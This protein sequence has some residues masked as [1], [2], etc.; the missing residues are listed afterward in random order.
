MLRC[1]CQ[2]N[3]RAAVSFGLYAPLLFPTSSVLFG[4]FVPFAPTHE[5]LVLII[6]P[7]VP[8]SSSSSCCFRRPKLFQTFARSSFLFYSVAEN[9]N[10]CQEVAPF[11]HNPIVD[12]PFSPAWLPFTKHG[13]HEDLGPKARQIHPRATL[14][15]V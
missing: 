13:S 2:Y 9:S 4:L 14:L 8:A 6:Q 11:S 1:H 12:L 15:R 5:T 7:R 10:T 3:M